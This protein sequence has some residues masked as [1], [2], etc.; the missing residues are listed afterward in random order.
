MWHGTIMIVSNSYPYKN[1]SM[2]I[3]SK[4]LFK[5]LDEK[6]EIWMNVHSRQ[7]NVLEN[8]KFAKLKHNLNSNDIAVNTA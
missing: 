7:G 2:Y 3:S 1:T 8:P 4:F 5:I 6:T